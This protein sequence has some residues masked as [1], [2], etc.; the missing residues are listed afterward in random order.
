MDLF[1]SSFGSYVYLKNEYA[2][3][4]W[5]DI[6]ADNGLNFSSCAN[7]AFLSYFPP[8]K[9]KDDSPRASQYNQ[10]KHQL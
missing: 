5:Q 4:T 3:E 2:L 7:S 9:S 1:C 6:R 10:K 8:E